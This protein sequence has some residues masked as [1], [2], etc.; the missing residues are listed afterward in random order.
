MAKL[1]RSDAP[2]RLA[3][4]RPEPL[5]DQRAFPPNPPRRRPWFLLLSALGVAV[6]LVFLLWMAL[7][8]TRI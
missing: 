6:W 2:P 8:D 1:E 3:K 4:P 7:H 5:F